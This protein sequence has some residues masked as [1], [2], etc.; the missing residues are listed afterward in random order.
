M[1][2]N[3]QFR[4]KWVGGLLLIVLLLGAS[5]TVRVRQ[6][7]GPKKPESILQGDYTYTKA[8]AQYL[9]EQVMR[10]QHIPGAAMVMIDDQEI[11]WQA[12]FGFSDVEKEIPVR[13]DTVF[14]LWSLAKPFTAIEI[15]RLV[16]AG[17]L[18]LDVPL[19]E[20]VPGFSIQSRYARGEPITLRHILAHRSGLPRNA[21]R[22]GFE[23]EIG[24]EALAKLAAALEDCTLAYPTGERYKYSNIGYDILGYLI[25]AESGRPYPPHMRDQLLLPIGMADSAFYS[26][27]LPPD[28]QLALGYEYYQ[29]EYYAYEQLDVGT[30][31]SGNLYATID[32]LA[33]FVK[34][35]FREGETGGVHLISPDTLDAMYQDQYSRPTDPQPMGLGW[36]LGHVLESELLVWHDGGASEGTGSLIA[37]LP[38]RKLGVVLLGNAITLEGSVSLPIAIEILEI[39][40]ETHG[41]LAADRAE[42]TNVMLVDPSLLNLYGGSYAIFGDIL[43]VSADEDRLKGT[44]QGMRFDL[45]PVSENKFVISHWL[46]KLGL[47]DLLQFPMDLG[48]LEFEFQVGGETSSGGMIVNFGGVNYEICPR[49]PPLPEVSSWRALAGK[50]EI[51]PHLASGQPGGERLGESH[52]T[53]DDGRLFMSGVVGPILPIDDNT[54]VI[55][56]GSFNGETIMRDPENGYLTRQGLVY[57]PVAEP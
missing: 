49:Y 35:M 30:I 43:E 42:P 26:T 12:T 8:V 57:K 37:M 50:Y 34:F 3:M 46:L 22:Y 24:P 1:K 7:R 18:D 20:Y 21:C 6:S 4:W 55:L 2:G 39:M 54:L 53:W 25:Q 45:V 5:A 14:K 44:I 36:K 40:L 52:I 51:Y 38:E 31:P 32:D 29:G 23:W 17:R 11:I 56:S 33:T 10:Q 27:D 41:G 9:V 19:S 48:K 15:M 16:D 47:A 13:N 28:S